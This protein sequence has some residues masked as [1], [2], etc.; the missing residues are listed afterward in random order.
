MTRVLIVAPVGSDMH[1]PIEERIARAAVAADTEVVVRHLDGVPDSIYVSPEEVFVPPLIEAVRQ[2]ERDG[3]DAIGISCCSDPALAE[4]R[5][6]VSVPVCAPFDAVTA[7]AA[8]T[9]E[10][11]GVLY[12]VVEPAPGESELRGEDWIP[13]L[14]D[15]Y[16]RAETVVTALPVHAARPRLQADDP[17]ATPEE[18]GAALVA[19]MSAAIE[20]AGIE[21]ARLAEAAGAQVLFPTCTYWAGTLEAV[22]AA[23]RVPVLDPIAAL[24]ASL[25]RAAAAHRRGSAP[26]H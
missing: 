24:A 2:G 4:C 16:G 3:F 14:L 22:R 8:E 17:D 15:D 5:A 23:V 7:A 9:G 10:R 18:I 19:S 26:R 11:V 6:A 25:E 20:G 21:Q 1:A 13:Q 12:L